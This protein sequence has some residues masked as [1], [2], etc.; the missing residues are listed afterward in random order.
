M[1]ER[2]AESDRKP[3]SRDQVATIMTYANELPASDWKRWALSLGVLTGA[4][5]GEIYQ[6]TQGDVKQV[7][8]ITVIDI[9]KDEQDKTLKNDFSVRQVPLVDGAYG[10]SLA[11][12]LEWVEREPGTLVQG[13]GPLLQQAAQ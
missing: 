11:A 7:E 13:Q 9:N 8:G 2:G 10:F 12:F 1:I 6:L 4:R 3:F 5:I